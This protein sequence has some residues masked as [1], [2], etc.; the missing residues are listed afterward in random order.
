MLASVTG[1]TGARVAVDVSV[2]AIMVTHGH[3][4]EVA[5]PQVPRTGA[6]SLSTDA[7][8]VQTLSSVRLSRALSDGRPLEKFPVQARFELKV[9][10]IFFKL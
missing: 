6:V 10:L 9:G 1:Q 2:A 3:L 7:A 8:S 5:S 4:A